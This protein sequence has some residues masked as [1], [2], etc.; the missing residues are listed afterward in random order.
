MSGTVP[1][2][3][4][5]YLI[6][7]AGPFFECCNDR[8]VNWSKIPF[9]A[10]ES[11]GGLDPQK[12]A[13][14]RVAFERHLAR[15]VS[16]GFNAISLDDLAHCVTF[17]FYPP[18]LQHKLA[19]YQQFYDELIALALA[20]GVQ[21]Y[22]NTDVAFFHASIARHTRLNPDRIRRFFGR[23]VE[24]LYQRFPGVAGIILRLGESD[25]LDVA[26]DFHSKLVVRN[27]R[28]CRCY[29]RKL[30]QISEQL[31]KFLIV[32]TWT[33]GAFPIGDL[34]WNTETYA[35]VFAGFDSDWLITSHKYGE[36]DFFRYLSMSPLFYGGYPRKIIELQARR[37]YEGFGA[38][39]SFIGFDYEK[40]YRYL[41]SCPALY[42]ISVWAQTGGWS[43]FK[44]ITFGTHS[45]VWNELNVYCTIKI[46]KE[47]Q[48]AERAIL[49]F[50]Q[51][52]F[53]QASG[54][55]LIVLLRL[56]DRVIKDLWYIPEFAIKRLYFRR[57]RVPPI[58][59]IFWDNIL[60]NHTVRKIIRRFV[61]EKREAVTDGYRALGK[62]RE[63][64]DLAQEI[65]IDPTGFDYQFD[66]FEIIAAARE[67][68]FGPWDADVA[69]RIMLLAEK[70]HVNYP[71]GFHF[72]VDFRPVPLNKWLIK[73]IFYI[74][75][76]SRPEYRLI[77]RMFL[78]RFTSLGYPLFHLW[79]KR[80]LPAFT[81]DR[82]MGIQILFK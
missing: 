49:T 16:L 43:H 29:L 31:E 77:D 53:P 61:M 65:G 39:P 69:V 2:P 27:I 56:A 38:F 64:R 9:P 15:I 34:I 57:T 6:D 7:A 20:K 26:G 35:A 82:A 75:L 60:I 71:S 72:L 50:A 36:S 46:F 66:T 14:V 51:E 33:L 1:T 58:F 3:L 18:Q 48:S 19:Q 68:F 47:H 11:E 80:R 12:C 8:E 40:Y 13:V 5:L 41:A 55:K 74:S 37:E 70:Y 24:A 32:R 21:V 79:Q 73:T 62:I 52:Y 59:W 10:L 45:S 4:Q 78:L 28:D 76:R 22:I 17:P 25:G 67:Y 42:G 30:L 81:R 23:C 63:M 54:E 44:D